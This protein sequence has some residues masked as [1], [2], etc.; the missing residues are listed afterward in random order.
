MLVLSVS[1]FLLVGKDVELYL[2][3]IYVHSQPSEWGCP[4]QS[5]T[6]MSAFFVLLWAVSVTYS[7]TVRT[8]D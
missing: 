1:V 5:C 6:E 4:F 3:M 8:C 7:A 2:F